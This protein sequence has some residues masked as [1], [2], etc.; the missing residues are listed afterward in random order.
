MRGMT[1]E[2]LQWALI[3]GLIA[4]NFYLLVEVKAMQKSTHQVT[5]MDP[6][7]DKKGQDFQKVDAALGE[8]LSKELFDNIV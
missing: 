4:S 6:F 2:L 1:P 5:Y 3:L 8:E 7:A